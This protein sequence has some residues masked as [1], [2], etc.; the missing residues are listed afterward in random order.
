MPAIVAVNQDASAPPNIAF[1]TNL[2]KSFFLSG[3]IEPIPPSCI[4]IDAKFSLDNYNK[5]I[6]CSNKEELADLEK[7]FFGYWQS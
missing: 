3:A 6:E 4:P 1:V 7:H 5:M 2:A